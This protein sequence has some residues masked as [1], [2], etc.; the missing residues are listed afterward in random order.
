MA[1]R[2]R[3]QEEFENVMK[4]KREEKRKELTA[5][6]DQ[7]KEQQQVKQL[8]SNICIGFTTVVSTNLNYRY[9]SIKRPPRISTHPQI[10]AYPS[11]L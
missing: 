7:F 6:Q 5:M 3:E 8:K 11:I 4:K 1:K 10:S 2:Q 9:A